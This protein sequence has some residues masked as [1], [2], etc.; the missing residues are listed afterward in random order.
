MYTRSTY[1]RSPLRAH[2]RRRTWQQQS[3]GKSET[4]KSPK[5][6]AVVRRRW[7]VLSHRARVDA[8]ISG[9]GKWQCICFRLFHYRGP[10][11]EHRRGSPPE[12]IQAESIAYNHKQAQW[13]QPGQEQK[14]VASRAGPAQGN[15]EHLAQ[16]H[17]SKRMALPEHWPLAGGWPPAVKELTHCVD[18]PYSHS[19]RQAMR[20]PQRNRPQHSG[21]RTHP[22]DPQRCQSHS[23][24]SRSA[25][26][27]LRPCTADVNRK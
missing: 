1:A 11:M 13:P 26:A 5:C 6:T 20:S 12:G 18:G 27:C 25:S 17:F 23:K 15:V 21:L 2:T 8:E 24:R 4:R 7:V 14:P 16:H 10:G 22:K 3:L 19:A 9:S